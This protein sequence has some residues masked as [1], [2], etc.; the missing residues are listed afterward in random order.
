MNE[1]EIK[2][3]QE[4]ILNK[5]SSKL[6]K[7]KGVDL[8]EELEKMIQIKN[9]KKIQK[10]KKVIKITMKTTLILIISIMILI[11]IICV[12]IYD[13]IVASRYRINIKESIENKYSTKVKCI[14]KDIGLNKNG[15]YIFKLKENPDI[16]IHVIKK[17]GRTEE[18]GVERYCKYYFEKWEDEYKSKFKVKEGFRESTLYPEKSKEWLLSYNICIDINS[19]QELI[20]STEAIIRLIKYS[21]NSLVAIYIP[22][23]LDGEKI[24]PCNKYPI[25]EEEIR[26]S[27]KEQYVQLVKRKHL[28]TNDIPKNILEK[29]TIK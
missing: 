7:Y 8:K 22:L 28:N 1:K 9:N 15:I 23:I 14:Y 5:E 24:Y 19:Y 29:Y 16:K 2:K 26:E 17:F 3:I 4:D 11:L 21:K 6:A 13:T 25:T 18:D 12:W 10:A 27:A 20:K